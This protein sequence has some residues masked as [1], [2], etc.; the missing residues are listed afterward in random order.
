MLTF[1]RI[2]KNKKKLVSLTTL[3]ESEFLELCIYFKVQHDLYFSNKNLFGKKRKREFKF[4][5]NSTFKCVEDMLLF[6]LIYLK[7]YPLQEVYA[8]QNDMT[9]PQVAAWTKRLKPFLT[10]ALKE[11][12]CTPSRNK[13]GFKELLKTNKIVF[14]DATERQIN[15]PTDDEIQREFY[16]GK[17][18]SIQ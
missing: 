1:E 7:T 15:R 2:R 3:A 13:T 4:K 5:A 14:Q 9:Q 18:K 12:S 6:L 10:K 16:S 8:A 17:K 11:L